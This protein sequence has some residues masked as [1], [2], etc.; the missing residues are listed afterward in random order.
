MAGDGQKCLIAGLGNPGSAYDL[1]RHN[2]GFEVV[3]AYAKKQGLSFRHAADFIGDLAQGS[4]F[5]KKVFLLLPLTYMNSSGEAIRACKEYFDIKL[6]DLL[7]ICD[8]AA[9]PFGKLRF[10]AK[11]SSG[12][13]NGLQSI[14][15]HL[16]TTEY[17]R[18][19]IGI[20]QEGELADYVL[21]KFTPE[22]TKALPEV[23]ETVGSAI[24][25]W[26]SSGIEG[27]MRAF[28]IE[29]KETRESGE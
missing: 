15:E 27:A 18:L 13:H 16:G 17:P 28:N 26:L 29:K 24:D 6:S 7:V 2:I 11:G 22:E 25:K 8:D 20:G 3:R 1:T 12:G 5:G 4:L 9:L 10:R 14:A 19:R 23:A 21:G